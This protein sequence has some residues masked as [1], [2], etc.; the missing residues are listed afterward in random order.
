MEGQ[1]IITCLILSGTVSLGVTHFYHDRERRKKYVYDYRKHMFEKRMTTYEKIEQI[2][3]KNY[4][5]TPDYKTFYSWLDFDSPI[6][7]SDIK[8]YHKQVNG[9]LADNIWINIPTRECLV[10]ISTFLEDFF[11]REKDERER[12][13]MR[14]HRELRTAFMN[15]VN[16]LADYGKFVQNR[17]F[18]RNYYTSSVQKLNLIKVR[19]QI[20][21]R[22]HQA[23]R[24]FDNSAG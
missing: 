6:K 17:F 16:M 1:L 9:A 18:D 2:I 24:I 12:E 11:N 22:I 13:Y 20:A 19:R 23:A 15:D 14:L 21:K 8:S 4:L 7:E 3:A 10:K 5:I